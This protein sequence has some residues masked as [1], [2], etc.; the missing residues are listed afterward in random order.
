MFTGTVLCIVTGLMWSMIACVRRYVAKNGVPLFKF[1]CISN[2]MASIVCWLVYLLY[3]PNVSFD[4][5]QVLPLV[6]LLVAAGFINS[7][8]E[9]FN[10]N[11]FKYGH[12]GIS[13]A[14]S[15][16]SIA[17]PFL[18]SIVF[19][20]EHV[21]WQRWLGFL[22]LLLSLGMMVVQE[23]R[24]NHGQSGISARDKVIWV[25]LL[26][27]RILF[28]GTFL[29]LIIISSKYQDVEAMKN[30][31]IPLVMTACA[32]GNGFF[33]QFKFIPG[34][35]EINIGKVIKV[36]LIWVSL[37][38]GSYYFQFLSVDRMASLGSAAIV[39]PL[40]VCAYLSSF[41]LYSHLKLKEPYNVFSL[42]SLLMCICGIFLLSS[43]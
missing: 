3:N 17:I 34:N 42:S 19:M 35:G 21:I 2:G 33:S 25:S 7:V 29:T 16:S 41:S 11:C 13:V 15:N 1:Y 24:S 18:Y 10:V 31:R 9:A 12:N 36:S 20:N 37:A 6:V 28:T 23:Y 32:L 27:G 26:M 43:E 39:F 5:E 4:W 14:A 40:M 22:L 38:V 30:L 8:S